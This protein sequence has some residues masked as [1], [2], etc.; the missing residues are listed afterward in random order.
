[1]TPV[2]LRIVNDVSFATRINRACR[3]VVQTSTGVVRSSTGL[4]LCST[5]VVL[6]STK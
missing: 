1:M 5:G 3:I 4:V 2:A 6:C